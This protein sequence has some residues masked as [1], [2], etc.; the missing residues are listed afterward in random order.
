MYLSALEGLQYIEGN[1]SYLEALLGSLLAACL[2]SGYAPADTL[3]GRLMYLL[4]LETLPMPPLT[5]PRDSPTSTASSLFRHSQPF[6]GV[7]RQFGRGLFELSPRK[8]GGVS[9]YTAVQM[10]IRWLLML[11]P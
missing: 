10:L 1:E 3:C 9:V 6:V 7:I 2:P 4:M 11:L 5:F 8:E